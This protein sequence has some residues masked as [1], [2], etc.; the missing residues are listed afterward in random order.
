M[1]HMTMRS[2]KP[3]CRSVSAHT[4]PAGPAEA[5]G[6]GV[7]EGKKPGWETEATGSPE[8]MMRTWLNPVLQLMTAEHRAMAF[9]LLCDCSAWKGRNHQPP[10]EPPSPRH[11]YLLTCLFARMTTLSFS[12]LTY[13][14]QTKAAR[15]R[16]Q[17]AQ[18]R[19]EAGDVLQGHLEGGQ[20]V[21]TGEVLNVSG[22]NVE[23]RAVPRTA[24]VS[25]GQH[26]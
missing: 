19:Q 8:P 18:R 11:R 22:R 17:D 10:E 4:R 16:Y 3:S 21:Q 24:H 13:S 6:R 23:A 2:V 9:D 25:F 1:V 15:K 26:T 5:I 14:R 12:T 20:A 7:K